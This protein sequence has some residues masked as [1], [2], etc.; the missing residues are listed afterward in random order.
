MYLC[1]HVVWIIT[2]PIVMATL[3]Y[4][5]LTVY[6]VHYGSDQWSDNICYTWNL[7]TVLTK[8]LI[9]KKKRADREG[10]IIYIIDKKSVVSGLRYNNVDSY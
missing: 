5:F 7:K 8:L 1:T 3:F 2:C 9:K 6:N 4:P 10:L